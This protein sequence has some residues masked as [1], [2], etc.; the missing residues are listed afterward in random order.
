MGPVWRVEVHAANVHG[1]VARLDLIYPD[2]TTNYLG[3]PTYS[4]MV[5]FT[6]G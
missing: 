3:P 4:P 1:G 2:F 6:Y 5:P